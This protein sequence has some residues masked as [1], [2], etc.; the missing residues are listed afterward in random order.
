M[1]RLVMIC[2]PFIHGP[3]F[4]I[5]YVTVLI[6]ATTQTPA[7]HPVLKHLLG[8]HGTME[9]CLKPN[10]LALGSCLGL[11]V[12]SKRC[13]NP[14]PGRNDANAFLD[15]VRG[16][17]TWPNTDNFIARIEEF[18]KDAYCRHHVGKI[19]NAFVV[20]KAKTMP[21][22]GS[23]ADTT[24]T[25]GGGNEG[26]HGI[27]AG[28]THVE[29]NHEAGVSQRVE[30][31]SIE[32]VVS[33]F[34]AMSVSTTTHTVTS[35]DLSVSHIE[36]SR[37]RGLGMAELARKGSVRDGSK[38]FSEMHKPLTPIQQ[39]EGIVYVLRNTAKNNLFKIGFSTTT[40]EDRLNQNGNCLKTNADVEI[41]YETHGGPFFAAH[42]AER[43]AQ[44]VLKNHNLLIKKCDKCEGGHKEWFQAPEKV[45][46]NAVQSME[47]F[48]RLPAY[49]EAADGDWKLSDAGFKVVKAMCH[50]DLVKL[51]VFLAESNSSTIK[52]ENEVFTSQV[53]R[54][55]VVATS[56]EPVIPPASPHSKDSLRGESTSAATSPLS[57]REAGRYSRRS[58]GTAAAV[59]G[60]TIFKTAQT[61]RSQGGETLYRWRGGTPDTDGAQDNGIQEPRSESGG[62][63]TLGNVIADIL[64]SVMPED[65][66]GGKRDDAKVPVMQRGVSWT[67]KVKQNLRSQ[68]EDYEKEW[69]REDELDDFA[70]PSR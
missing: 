48:V 16:M 60:K 66:S 27:S 3:S 53:Q 67:T 28:N 68:F 64:W 30:D 15:D 2:A 51:E 25:V 6:M 70:A 44:T 9:H 24:A 33:Q 11:T 61:I 26:V 38:I 49:V 20:W 18:I 45:V 46:M 36:A 22:I 32:P 12:S 37:I 29:A 43:L 23:P 35:R 56:E 14:P 31:V 7:G 63:N 69:N 4:L 57:G 5:I 40:A 65:A 39:K 55:T 19:V 34:T 8:I 13:G 41:L 54:E 17:E 50:L 1:H 62:P 10:T 42:K 21:T 47:G 58:F 52:E 59:V